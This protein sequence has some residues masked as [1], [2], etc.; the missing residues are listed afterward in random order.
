MLIVINLLKEIKFNVA[1]KTIVSTLRYVDD[2]VC[3]YN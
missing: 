1:R 3:A 2:V